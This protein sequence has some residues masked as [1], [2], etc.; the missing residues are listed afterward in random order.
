MY[1]E[2][3]LNNNV[4]MTKNES[5]EEIVC[6]GRGLAFQKKIGDLI[7]PTFIEKEFVLK[8][9]ITSG[10]FQQLFA[11]IPLEE[12]EIVKRIVDMAE[13]DLG[14]ELSSNIYL[15][16]T[17]H[18]HYAIMRAKEGIEMPNPL[19]F[20]TK[21]FYP[22]EYAIARKGVALIK[23][24]LNID[25]SES[26]AGFIA[27]HIVN[28]E[29]ANGNIE[30]TMSATEMVRDILTIISR[31]FGKPFDEDSLNYQRIV[32][33]LQYFAQ[34]YLQNEAHDEEDDFLYELIQC[35]YPKAFQSVQRINDYL[36]KKYQKPIDK[37][38]QIYLTIH[39]QRVAG[40]KKM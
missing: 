6:M 9:S 35:K 17:D 20:E 25:F 39:I 33:H 1:I 3:I 24:K 5:G 22:K 31:Y 28:S 27:F 26:E 13:D 30:V 32:T 4:V 15:T 8:D 14:I 37:A 34:R 36:V 11:D 12:V 16:L 18:V 19:M 21:K 38:E 7:D 23:E 29:Q 2:K 10:Q 40:E